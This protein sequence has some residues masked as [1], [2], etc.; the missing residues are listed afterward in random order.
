M[1]S[2]TVHQSELLKH[3]GFVV[4]N[5]NYC[6]PTTLSLQPL[7]SADYFFFFVML[8]RAGNKLEN[9]LPKPLLHHGTCLMFFVLRFTSDFQR[10]MWKGYVCCFC[11][12]VDSFASSAKDGTGIKQQISTANA[13]PIRTS[14]G[15][16]R[17]HSHRT[18][19][20]FSS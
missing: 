10:R 17:E 3:S 11:F 12:V 14:S 9:L 7:E 4:H 8:M 1:K 2:F 19:F 6:S 18:P 20:G 13:D 15:S 5:H 16:R